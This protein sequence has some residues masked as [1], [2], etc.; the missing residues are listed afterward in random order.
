M[1]RS[2]LELHV[3][4]NGNEQENSVALAVEF[5]KIKN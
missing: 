3:V 5:E 2:F 1:S 4:W